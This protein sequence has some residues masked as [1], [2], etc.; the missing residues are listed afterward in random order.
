MSEV[1]I[2]L[3]DFSELF[4]KEKAKR[5][6]HF[7]LLDAMG[8]GVKET[9]HSWVLGRLLNYKSPEGN[10]DILQSWLNH[11][12]DLFSSQQDSQPTIDFKINKPE[13]LVERDSI[14]ILVMDTGYAIIVENKSNGAAD[15]EAQL[16]RYIDK[17]LKRGYRREQIFV[18]YLPPNEAKD[19]IDN[20]WGSYEQEFKNRY[21]KLSWQDDILPWLKDRIL[22][23]VRHK[24]RYLVSA[25][26]QYIDH[27][28]GHYGY[29]NVDRDMNAVLKAFVV[30]T[31]KWDT[32][33]TS[34]KLATLSATIQTIEAM[35]P[36]IRNL[37]DPFKIEAAEKL[38]SVLRG[39]GN[40]AKRD[41][42]SAFWSELHDALTAKGYRVDH[43]NLT[44]DSILKSYHESGWFDVGMQ[45]PFTVKGTEHPF[46]FRIIASK[47]AGFYGFLFLAE[48]GS[49]KPESSN[50]R[51]TE[52][53]RSLEAC[54]AEAMPRCNIW[55]SW[56]GCS[57]E[58][59]FWFRRMYL[60][61]AAERLSETNRQRLVH[62][63]ADRF[64]GCIKKFIASAEKRGL[65][66]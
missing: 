45:I 23:N 63:L 9:A 37:S 30:K 16:S 51:M 14:D 19:P 53:S 28:D 62:D 25:L 56:Y 48:D 13:I 29:R 57:V 41:L 60:R 2:L 17:T 66:R 3:N 8:N 55:P 38:T 15:Q 4:L 11:F 10:F 26:E 1:D 44:P 34:A 21:A 12:R 6:Y 49:G 5:P 32:A 54:A 36:E 52:R 24:D 64:D 39:L 35:L 47:G 31:L 7:N 61:D 42:E 27:W 20:T 40:Q 22:P 59:S 58:K 43:L 33:R 65:N 46:V 50:I 18:M